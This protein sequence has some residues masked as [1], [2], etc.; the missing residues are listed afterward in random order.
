[1]AA[2]GQHGVAHG[3]LHMAAPTTIAERMEA[4]K[5]A[6]GGETELALGGGGMSATATTY[7]LA[8]SS[9]PAKLGEVVEAANVSGFRPDYG[10][11]E[12][13]AEPALDAAVAAEIVESMRGA[14]L[15][16]GWL[17]KSGKGLKA[18]VFEPRFCVM[19]AEPSL[20]FFADE[21]LQDA[22]G[23]PLLLGGATAKREGEFVLLNVPEEVQ[24]SAKQRF[25]QTKLQAGSE[26]EADLWVARVEAAVAGEPQ[27][28]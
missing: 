22:K 11:V 10:V 26:A 9:E 24:T 27:P 19:Y 1:M 17:Q 14:V 20:T 18:K 4:L 7:S 5:V 13:D 8:P 28:P 25:Q 3:W 6:Q 23:S 15:A 21:S 16:S 12:A 2:R